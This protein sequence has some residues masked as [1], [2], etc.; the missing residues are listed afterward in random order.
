MVRANEEENEKERKGEKVE[1]VER[2]REKI[3][4]K[5][6]VEVSFSN[7]FSSFCTFL[8]NANRKYPQ[9]FVFDSTRK[10]YFF[11]HYFTEKGLNNEL[12]LLL[13]PFLTL[14]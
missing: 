10:K 4:H 6:W 9:N 2:E 1:R 11:F 12:F 3:D 8:R 5:T 14:F 7:S 13:Q